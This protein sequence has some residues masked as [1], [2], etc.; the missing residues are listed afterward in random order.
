MILL[1]ICFLLGPAERLFGESFY[2]LMKNAL[3]E[4]GLLCV[5]GTC[6]AFLYEGESALVAPGL[7]L[8]YLSFG[9]FDSSLSDTTERVKNG[10][11]FEGN[12]FLDV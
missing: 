3:K 6:R 2:V 7:N 11:A 10:P 12:G 1:F 8:L 4:D 5:Q 9:C